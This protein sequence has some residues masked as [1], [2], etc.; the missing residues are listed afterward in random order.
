MGRPTIRVFC[1]ASFQ[2]RIQDCLSWIIKHF[3]LFR[4]LTKI[5]IKINNSAKSVLENVFVR[6]LYTTIL[7]MQTALTLYSFIQ[8]FGSCFLFQTKFDLDDNLNIP[9]NKFLIMFL[10]SMVL[11]NQVPRSEFSV[12]SARSNQE[13]QNKQNFLKKIHPIDSLTINIRQKNHSQSRL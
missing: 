6:T 1:Y 2:W 5:F 9:I 12:I 8:E 10:E 3:C 7:I 4:K 11:T 13:P